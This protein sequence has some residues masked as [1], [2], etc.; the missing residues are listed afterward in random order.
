MTRRA[1]EGSSLMTAGEKRDT[2]HV[3]MKRAFSFSITSNPSSIVRC[4]L[5][6]LLLAGV[7]EGKRGLL[8]NFVSCCR[9]LSP[10]REF[11]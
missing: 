11:A 6:V 8:E 1:L 9:L 10:C 2:L 7:N 4:V 5:A 3:L